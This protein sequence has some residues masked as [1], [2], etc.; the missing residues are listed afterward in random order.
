MGLIAAILQHREERILN[1]K[2]RLY[3]DLI[4]IAFADN[5]YSEEERDFIG[6]VVDRLGD[7]KVGEYLSGGV[8][9]VRELISHVGIYYE[10]GN[11]QDDVNHWIREWYSIPYP[12]SEKK[13]VTYLLLIVS[14]MVCDGKCAPKEIAICNQMAENM[15]LSKRHV[16]QCILYIARQKDTDLNRIRGVLSYYEGQNPVII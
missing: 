11:L 1:E 9:T 16:H 13:R 3:A 15:G 6:A 12:R 4:R 8:I 10:T 5:I 14:I 7:I 2:K